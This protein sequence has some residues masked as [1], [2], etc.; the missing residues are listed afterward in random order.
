[1]NGVP[2][3]LRTI[4]EKVQ[5]GER[6]RETVR[7]LL[8]WF[9]QHR[10]G[11]HVVNYIRLVLES[12][13]LKTDPDFELAFFDGPVEFQPLSEPDPKQA[14]GTAVPLAEK[15]D[16]PRPAAGD[17]KP[18]KDPVMRVDILEAANKKNLCTVARDDLLEEAMAHMSMRNFSQLPVM[19]GD[20]DV[21][22]M[23]SWKSIGEAAAWGKSCKFVR[24]C[25]EHAEVI[26]WDTP[27]ITAVSKIVE[28]QVVLVAGHDGRVTGLITTTDLALEFRKLSEPFLLL[29][30]IEN[31]VR[32]IIQ[33]KFSS[34][35]LA[36][37]KNPSDSSRN[38]EDVSDLAMGEYIRLLQNPE[39][40]KRLECKLDRK[41]FIKR[42]EEV[43]AIRN[44]VMHFHPDPLEPE[45]IQLLQEIARFFRGC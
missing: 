17:G 19:Q 41:T 10:R 24:D 13:R 2:Y 4:A 37:A 42:L 22:G 11:Q 36:A 29:G 27:L 32:R 21:R 35:E 39:N 25:M 14:A 44:D 6:P 3:Q 31:H 43:G 9:D 23:I 5:N 15:R 8:L 45:D 30:E 26:P 38:I 34:E 18:P 12:A 40:W 16:M 28:H 20:R 33:G 1:M 7:A